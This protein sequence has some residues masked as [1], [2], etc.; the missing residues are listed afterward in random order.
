[1]KNISFVMYEYEKENLE[2]EYSL[3]FRYSVDKIYEEKTCIDCKKCSKKIEEE[4]E[5]IERLKNWQQTKI[6]N[7]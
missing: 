3:I 2:K 7:Q 1:M 6:E 4:V 5:L